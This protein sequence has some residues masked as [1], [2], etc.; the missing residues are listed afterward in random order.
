MNGKT[1]GIHS[2]SFLEP[3]TTLKIKPF[4]G[5]EMVIVPAH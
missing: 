3:T 5:N 1:D 4:L 2:D